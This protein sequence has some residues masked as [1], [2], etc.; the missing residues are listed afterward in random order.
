MEQLQDEVSRILL[1]LSKPELI[2]VCQYLKCSEPATGG[3]QASGK[4][5]IIRLAEQRLEEITLEEY[6]E[7]K[8]PCR[9][10]LLS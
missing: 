5:P 6:P 3:F 1:T 4:R 8:V 10:A 9:K 7:V 2:L